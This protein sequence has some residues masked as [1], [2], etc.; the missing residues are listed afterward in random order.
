MNRTILSIGGFDHTCA[1]GVVA[2][3]KTFMAFRCYGVAVITSVA[4]QNSQGV[5]AVE[6][7]PMEY[8]AQQLESITSDM[9]VHAVKTGMLGNAR[10]VEIVASLL[11]SYE[12]ENIVVD[13]VMVSSTGTPLLDEEGI[14][15]LG[16]KLLPLASVVT[17]NLHEASVLS[18]I[19]VT[20]VPSMKEAAQAIFEKHGPRN[21]VITGG[22]L[23]GRA[24]DVLYDGKRSSVHDAAK[25]VT[26]N[27]RGTGCT[28]ASALAVHLARGIS[29]AEGIN[30]AKLYMVKAM[31]HPF[32]LGRLASPLNHAVPV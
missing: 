24:M 21:V 12:L 32:T 14:E 17:P 10:T 8:V 22:H 30:K 5:Q 3:L 2:D 16:D 9:E 18:G 4:A 31:A 15:A 6:P 11:G 25:I 1:A 20:D 28:F 13:P 19:E 29:L 26:K 23:E 27:S 7:I